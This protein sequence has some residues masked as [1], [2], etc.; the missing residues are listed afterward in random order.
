VRA[1]F[2]TKKNLALN[3]TL[4]I[5]KFDPNFLENEEK[6]KSIKA[7]ILGEG[8]DDDESGTE[9][10][11]SEDEDEGMLHSVLRLEF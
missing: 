9:E 4:D 3:F 7:E 8:S 1:F 10:S 6:Y 11:S 5:F 2:L